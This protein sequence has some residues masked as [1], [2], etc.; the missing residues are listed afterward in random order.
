MRQGTGSKPSSAAREHPE[1]MRALIIK[2]AERGDSCRWNGVKYYIKSIGQKCAVL[3]SVSDYL[4]YG[5]RGHN[6]YGN[7]I[8][9]GFR[10]PT[11]EITRIRFNYWNV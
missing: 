5:L 1:W 3:V 8:P 9:K 11:S 4:K 2:Q 6:L 7:H 10:V